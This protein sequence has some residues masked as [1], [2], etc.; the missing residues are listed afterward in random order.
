MLTVNEFLKSFF[1]FASYGIDALIPPDSEDKKDFDSFYFTYLVDQVR[2]KVL[3]FE[4]N[5][6]FFFENVL[7]ESI[8]QVYIA[9]NNLSL[10]DPGLTDEQIKNNAL[11]QIIS[12][13]IK[14]IQPTIVEKITSSGFVTKGA[15]FEEGELAQEFTDPLQNVYQT[16]LNNILASPGN[17]NPPPIIEVDFDNHIT[18]I[19]DGFYSKDSEGKPSRLFNGGFF[20][21]NGFEV[22]HK[23]FGESGVFEKS[24]YDTIFLALP[25]KVVI[26]GGPFGQTKTFL[27][28]LEI[29]Q[30]GRYP[31]ANFNDD[32]FGGANLSRLLFGSI[33]STGNNVPSYDIQDVFF[34]NQA[35]QYLTSD[36]VKELSKIDGYISYDS[37]EYQLYRNL[38]SFFLGVNSVSNFISLVVDNLQFSPLP[39]H[40]INAIEQQLKDQS[41]YFSSFAWL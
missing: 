17:Y 5:D 36:Q 25:E 6:I 23:R 18:K 1:T 15:F 24:L 19:P 31:K 7:Q 16:S 21:E 2:R 11:R 40:A 26:G 39:V 27:T 34:D 10:D 30:S 41:K 33:S 22:Q 14:Q 29:Q 32:V 20:L 12:T 3:I 35:F 28:P 9:N 8:R 13:S 37:T 4:Q 38:W